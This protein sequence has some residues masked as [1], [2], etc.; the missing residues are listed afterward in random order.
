[1][2]VHI[3]ETVMKDSTAGGT[4]SA[5][6]LSCEFLSEVGI[7]IA[8]KPYENKR[9]KCGNCYLSTRAAVTA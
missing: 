3:T 6:I 2:A 9:V 1:M 5:D 8:R 7:I 4:K